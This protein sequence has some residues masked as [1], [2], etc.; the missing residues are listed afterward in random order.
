MSQ[1]PAC[2]VSRGF[3]AASWIWTSENNP[4]ETVW[5]IGIGAEWG[6]RRRPRG[7][8][9][10][11]LVRFVKSKKHGRE[12]PA[13]FPTVSPRTPVNRGRNRCVLANYRGAF[14]EHDTMPPSLPDLRCSGDSTPRGRDRSS[15]PLYRAIRGY[16]PPPPRPGGARVRPSRRRRRRRGGCLRRRSGRARLVEPYPSCSS[17]LTAARTSSKGTSLESTSA[18]PALRNLS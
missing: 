11:Q 5:K 6:F 16:R 17:L 2:E 3:Y 15:L 1:I 13:I 14:P 18:A 8:E 7:G 12:A 4:S 10:A 9:E